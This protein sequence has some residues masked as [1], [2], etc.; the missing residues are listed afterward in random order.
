MY[1]NHQ[2]GRKG[3]SV[4]LLYLEQ[5][6]YKVIR[7]NWRYKHLEIDIVARDGDY[8]VF[9][10]VKTRKDASFGMPYEAVDLVKQRRL[11][12]AAERYLAVHPHMGDIRFDIVSVLYSDEHECYHAALIKDAFWPD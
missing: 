8:L 10:E 6:G 7:V 5:Q 12:R 1:G 2:T 4:A 3:E 11:V 9:V